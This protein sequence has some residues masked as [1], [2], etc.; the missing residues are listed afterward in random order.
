[1]REPLPLLRVQVRQPA[2][3]SFMQQ[4]CYT[5]LTCLAEDSMYPDPG[6]HLCSW[7]LA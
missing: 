2:L 4:P 1:V 6:S 3:T 7:K 5:P